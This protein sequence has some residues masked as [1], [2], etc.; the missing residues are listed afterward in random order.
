MTT[1][2]NAQLHEI[3][4]ELQNVETKYYD[5]TSYM[6]FSDLLLTDEQKKQLSYPQEYS[7]MNIYVL[8]QVYQ[9]VEGNDITKL[10]ITS[11]VK[12]GNGEI[13]GYLFD[14]TDQPKYDIKKL[15]NKKN[16]IKLNNQAKITFINFYVFYLKVYDSIADKSTIVGIY[17]SVNTNE[18]NPAVSLNNNK[19][20]SEISTGVPVIVDPQ[21]YETKL[22]GLSKNLV[23]Y[24]ECTE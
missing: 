2:Q 10:S 7:P 20:P 1:Q 19:L 11:Y 3:I 15:A 13:R 24:T 18:T 4:N 8:Q 23:K 21:N 17:V 5:H 9:S 16:A 22:V 12:N 14:I 6:I